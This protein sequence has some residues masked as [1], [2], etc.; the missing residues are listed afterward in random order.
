VV[1][2]QDFAP[3]TEF[4]CGNEVVLHLLRGS[5][6]SRKKVVGGVINRSSSADLLENAICML[7]ER[8]A[9]KAKKCNRILHRPLW[10]ALLN[11]FWLADEDTYRRAF[12]MCT[13]DHPFAR[14]ELVGHSGEVTT[15]FP[16]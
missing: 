15:L 5:R 7:T 12:A 9:T 3:R 13:V 14:L 10:L 1:A 11:W 8:I 4:I 16:Q 6:E 2:Q